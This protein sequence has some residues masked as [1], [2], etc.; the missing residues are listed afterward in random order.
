MTLFYFI[1]G[2][3]EVLWPFFIWYWIEKNEKR[4]QEPDF[5]EKF[6]SMYLEMRTNDKMAR[7]FVVFFCFRGIFLVLNLLVLKLHP[8][9]LVFCFA[10]EQSIYLLYVWISAPHES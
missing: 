9:I 2:A 10:I 5:K 4:L 6:E 8:Y 1:L 7:R 3:L